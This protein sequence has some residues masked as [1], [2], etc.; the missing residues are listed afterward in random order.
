MALFERPERLLREAAQPQVPGMMRTSGGPYAATMA[1]PQL[2]PISNVETRPARRLSR[3]YDVKLFCFFNFMFITI[4]QQELEACSRD[5][6]GARLQRMRRLNMKAIQVST[7]AA[8]GKT[9]LVAFN[10]VE[11]ID[12]MC[13][14]VFK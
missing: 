13:V 7:V 9:A 1:P 8:C 10:D 14:G 3:P 11:I 4:F 5:I 2:M 12:W 6:I